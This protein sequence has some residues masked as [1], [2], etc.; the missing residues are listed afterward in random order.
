MAKDY[1]EILGVARSA[2]KDEIK[3][4]FRKM[5]HKY[6]PDKGK[7]NEDKFKEANEA[8]QT[9]S[10]DSK[11]KQYDTF[12]SAYD[13]VGRAGAGSSGFEGFSGF[14]GQGFDFSQGFGSG[15]SESNFEGTP[16]EDIFSSIFGGDR[17][18][19]RAKQQTKGQDIQIDL[20]LTLEDVSIGATKTINLRKLILC[21]EC[22]GNGTQYGSKLKTCDI[23]NGIGTITEVRRI[24]FGNIEQKT[25]CDNCLGVGKVPEKKCAHCRGEGRK[26]ENSIINL[27][28]PAGVEDGQMLEMSGYGSAGLR[29]GTPGN[30][31]IKVHIEPHK[32]FIRKGS[33]ILYSASVPFTTLSLGGKIIVPT[34]YGNENIK[35]PAGTQA[36]SDMKLSGKGLPKL[37]GWGKGDQIIKIKVSVPTKLSRNAQRLLEDLK[38]ELE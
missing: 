37:G 24:L 2:S 7:G 21:E 28:I 26:N 25:V 4:A 6:H 23:C 31:Y 35:I 30:L 29:K 3:K 14:G 34:L 22:K 36:G 9:L 5:A 33:T 11:R 1:Y 17:A 20:N 18:R 13:G 10:N 15:F 32:D 19:S 38:Q 12:G 16:F 27:S 8:Y